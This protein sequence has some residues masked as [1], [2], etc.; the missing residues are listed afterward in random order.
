[1]T[2]KRQHF[3]T[4]IN[5]AGSSILDEPRITSLLSLPVSLWQTLSCWSK[6]CIR[7]KTGRKMINYDNLFQSKHYSNLRSSRS[8]NNE[9]EYSLPHL[10]EITG[11]MF[12]H[13]IAIWQHQ[14]MKIKWGFAMADPSRK[15]DNIL[16]SP[17][18]TI[19][20]IASLCM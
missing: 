9:Y 18:R 13:R 3:N 7:I 11:W 20:L 19:Y 15:F 2:L 14:K 4:V 5:C 10:L 1:L 8:T 17:L 12:K 16:G 6:Q